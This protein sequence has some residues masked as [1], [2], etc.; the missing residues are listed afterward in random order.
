MACR[1]GDQLI[2]MPS[3]VSPISFGGLRAS[4]VWVSCIASGVLEFWSSGTMWL[5]DSSTGIAFGVADSSV[6]S[7]RVR[8][9]RVQ[10]ND[11]S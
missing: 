5:L 10:V 7:C 4:V 11:V 3:S 6:V 1:S 2:L 9:S 8:V